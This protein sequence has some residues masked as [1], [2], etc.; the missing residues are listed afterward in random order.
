MW[1]IYAPG[2]PGPYWVSRDVWS[3]N[4]AGTGDSVTIPTLERL[5]QL[6]RP[7]AG[8]LQTYSGPRKSVGAVRV[9]R[10][11][12]T[13]IVKD[14]A[15]IAH[16]FSLRP[17]SVNAL[18]RIHH[19]S[20]DRRVEVRV[21]YTDPQIPEPDSALRARQAQAVEDH[22]RSTRW[23]ER[24]I[25]LAVAPD[26]PRSPGWLEIGD[27]ARVTLK[28][29]WGVHDVGFGGSLRHDN[30]SIDDTAVAAIRRVPPAP[31]TGFIRTIGLPEPS[32]YWIVARSPGRTV[33]RA[34]DIAPYTG[35]TPSRMP[36]NNLER[37]IV[38]IPPL[39]SLRGSAARDT[40]GPD[41]PARL[42][43]E[44]RDRAGVLVP[45]VVV[46]VRSQGWIKYVA[47]T[48]LVSAHPPGRYLFVAEFRQLRDSTWITRLAK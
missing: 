8:G 3:A 34:H 32:P 37:E 9:E 45:G 36:Q 10:G 13:L 19:D 25:E 21:T 6:G 44:A 16:M 7:A 12:V 47:D 41:Q 23:V 38:V 27:S 14:S 33:V 17:V 20:A 46:V 5:A 29:V 39:G 22:A 31:D 48:A 28:Q 35:L 18:W 26:W 1:G 43:V 24:T 2:T 4:A 42:R 15:V 11:R 30:W 40:V